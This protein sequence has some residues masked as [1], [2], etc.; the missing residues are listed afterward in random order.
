MPDDILAMHAA[1]QPDKVA[2]IEGSRR[3]TY[4]ELNRRANRVAHAFSG[5]GI[6]RHD[7]VAVMKH[8]SIE[9]FEISSGLRKIR[10]VGVP[11]NFRLRGPE[12]AYILNDSGA[13]VIVA[14]P[15]FVEV[16]ESVRDQLDG[17]RTFVAVGAPAPPGWLAYE[18]L[19]AAAADAE[20][21]VADEGGLGAAMIYTSGTTGHPKGAYRKDGV[22]LELVIETIQTFELTPQDVHL[23]AGPG[24]HSAVG[25]FTAP[26]VAHGATVVIMEKFDAERALQL[27]Q[28]HRVSTA[29]MAPILLKRVLDLPDEVRAGYDV[30]SMR[31]IYLGA[32]PCPF[33]LKERATA[34]FGEVLWEFYGA[35]ETGVNIVLRPPDQLRKPGSCGQVAP[36]SEVLLLDESGREVPDGEPGQIWVRYAGMA[37]YYNR[38]DATQNAMQDGFFTVG[39]IAYRD[40][41]GFYFIC[42]RL[43]DMIIS[44]GV[45]IYPAEIEAVLH[46]HPAVRDAAVIGVPD[47]DWGESVKAVV[48]LQPGAKATA[49]E[50]IA[51][52]AERLADYKKPRSVDFV[53]ELPRGVDGKLLKR[54][55]REPYWTAAGRSI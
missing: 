28:E 47:A 53:T 38:P 40:A 11:V 50:L 30:T 43:I 48:E 22:K 17:E 54:K 34:Y 52:S 25:L 37:E 14:G 5:L 9:G 3:A 7:R 26:S 31:G 12:V 42:D 36:G 8:N 35:T 51:W 46:A 21:V 39:D 18:E 4:A 49:E 32:A 19:L 2:L 29:Y 27:I 13:R 6:G 33:A 16:I 41:E 20:P 24:Y 10:A 44:G 55:V 45:N 1:A 23:M 15:G